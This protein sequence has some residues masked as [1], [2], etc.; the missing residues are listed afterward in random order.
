MKR[1]PEEASHR[2]LVGS[3][4]IVEIKGI[5]YKSR[6]TYEMI[7]NVKADDGTRNGPDPDLLYGE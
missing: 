4:F 2:Q 1:Q 3:F 7:L 5:L 6:T